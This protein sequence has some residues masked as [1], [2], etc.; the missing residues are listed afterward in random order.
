MVELDKKITANY[1]LGTAAVRPEHHHIFKLALKQGLQAP[2]LDKQE[3]VEMF[4]LSHHIGRAH[5]KGR[6]EMQ[7]LGTWATSRLKPDTH[8]HVQPTQKKKGSSQTTDNNSKHTPKCKRKSALQ[9]ATLQKKVKY[10]IVTS[11]LGCKQKCP[12]ESNPA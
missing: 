12:P 8:P 11:W 6:C 10:P 1:T 3:R 7:R 5:H 9:A 4:N 2:L